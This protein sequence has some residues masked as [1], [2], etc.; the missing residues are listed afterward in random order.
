MRDAR[1]LI[2]HRRARQGTQGHWGVRLG[3]SHWAERS[4]KLLQLLADLPRTALRDGGRR[5]KRWVRREAVGTAR[6]GAAR[7]RL[8]GW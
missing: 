7:G 6:V 1:E 4:L 2:R 8:A 3:G 5:A